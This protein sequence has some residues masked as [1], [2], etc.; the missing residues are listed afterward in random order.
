MKCENCG[1]SLSLE[2]AYC[3]HCGTVNKHAQQHVKDMNRYHG[4]FKATQRHV[5]AVVKN[6]AGISVRAAII[7]GLLILTVALGIVAS[8]DYDIKR[9]IMKGRA[10]RNWEEYS[11]HLD[12]LI[13]E[14]DYIALS[15]FAQEN[16]IDAYESPYE[17]YVSVLRAADQYTYLYDTILSVYAQIQ[18]EEQ[19]E[20]TSTYAKRLGEQLNYFYDALDMERYSYYQG[21]DSQSNQAALE[22]MEETATV[23]LQA[24]CGLTPEDGAELKDLTPAKRMVLLEERLSALEERMGWDF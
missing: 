20:D 24:Y 15:A 1:G 2:A 14:E 13:L 8:M 17:K 23:L 4:E 9:G 18:K 22:R 6:Y 5:Y 16:Y 10:E 19:W 11:A 21:A 12:Q 3:P 7:A